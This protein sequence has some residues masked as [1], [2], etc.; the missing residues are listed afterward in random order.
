MNIK[1][2][3]FLKEFLGALGAEKIIFS[4]ETNDAIRGTVLYK[5]NNSEETQDFCWNIREDKSPTEEALNIA[6]LLN[7]ENILSIDQITLTRSQLLHRY[8][9][10]YKA[11]IDMENFKSILDELESIEVSMVDEGKETDV[12]FIHE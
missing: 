6:R 2:K 8:N 9:E 3:T 10:R 1:R 4:E 11:N 7:E 12:Y 5:V